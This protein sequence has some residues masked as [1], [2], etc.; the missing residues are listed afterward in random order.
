MG[1]GE[2]VEEEVKREMEVEGGCGGRE[3]IRK[4]GGKGE[5]GRMASGDSRLAVAERKIAPFSSEDPVQ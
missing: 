3:S 4:S 1:V 2:S 5:G